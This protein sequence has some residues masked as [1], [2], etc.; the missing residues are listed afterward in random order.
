MSGISQR[1]TPLQKLDARA[2]T[3]LP[4]ALTVIVLLFGLT[5]TYVPG[6]AQ[7]TPLYILVAV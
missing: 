7:I 1:R 4:F 5:P 6:L 2:R 3:I